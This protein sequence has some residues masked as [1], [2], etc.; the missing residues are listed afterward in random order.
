MFACEFSALCSSDRPAPAS[1]WCN[2]FARP[3]ADLKLQDSPC[4]LAENLSSSGKLDIRSLALPPVKWAVSDL[5]LMILLGSSRGFD[6]SDFHLFEVKP[7][8][9]VGFGSGLNPFR[10][11]LALST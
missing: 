3:C 6:F 10:L 2:F 11:S 9:S 8:G 5:W 1:I 7:S 4:L